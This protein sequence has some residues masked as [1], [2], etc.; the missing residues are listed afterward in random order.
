MTVPDVSD[1]FTYRCREPGCSEPMRVVASELQPHKCRFDPRLMSAALRAVLDLHTRE[2]G[3]P[4][5]R[6][7][8]S[9]GE[10]KPCATEQAIT[11]ELWGVDA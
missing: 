3:T 11:D 5:V 4:N 8:A 9:D 6:R 7:C 2:Y 10:L 1:T